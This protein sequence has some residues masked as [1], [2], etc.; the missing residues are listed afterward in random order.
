MCFPIQ[1]L[2]FIQVEAKMKDVINTC[3]FICLYSIHKTWN[4][5]YFFLKESTTSKRNYSYVSKCK[6]QCSSAEPE[7]EGL[8]K[9]NEKYALANK[10]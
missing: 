5:G 7:V 9:K 1:V 4:E 10:K 2:Q 3:V 6:R 8:Q